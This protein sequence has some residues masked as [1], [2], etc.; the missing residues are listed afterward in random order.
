MDKWRRRLKVDPLDGLLG[1]GNPAISYFTRRD[2]LGESL[3]PPE[4]LWDLPDPVKMLRRQ[5]L[6]G[7]WRYASGKS[8]QSSG[9]DYNQLETFRQL[10]I[11]VEKYGFSRSHPAVA[12]AAGFLFDC[13]TYDG[14]F[15][16]IYASQYAPNY[17]GAIMELLIKAGWAE[18]KRIRRGFEWLLS[19]RQDDGGWAAAMRTLKI[20]WQDAYQL[21]EP[22]EPD[23]S[24]PFS[25]L[26][27]GM[28]LRAFAA[29]PTWRSAPAALAAAD[30]LAG[31]FFER[32]KY[33]DRQG[34][35]YWER[36]S[37]PFWFTDIVSALDSLSRLGFSAERPQIRRALA[38]LADRQA[39][40]GAFDLKLLK[41]R[42]KDTRWWVALAVCRV[43]VGLMPV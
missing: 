37:F 18:D 33:I 15:R 6:D 40:D 16:G 17:S 20:K 29:H 27:T 39:A 7:S 35:N 2:L 8:E 38:W 22:L 23:R 5:T 31:R 11:L 32:D 36:V 12:K 34:K 21:K 30:L 10:G 13:Q 41:T 3:G 4:L 24:R 25:H 28:A 26:M 43:F 1:C 9:E 19:N 14:D 42:D